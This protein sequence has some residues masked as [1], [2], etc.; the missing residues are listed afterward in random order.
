MRN[1]AGDF[2]LKIL[3]SVAK[4]RRFKVIFLIGISYVCFDLMYHS[5]LVFMAFQ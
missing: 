2:A 3:H 4:G 1:F 5:I